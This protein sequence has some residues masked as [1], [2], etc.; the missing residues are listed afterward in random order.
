MFRNVLLTLCL[1]IGAT[2]SH[3]ANAQSTDDGPFASAQ[4][5]TA[6]WQGRRAP[7]NCGYVI[8]ENQPIWTNACGFGP[9]R[10]INYYYCSNGW[11]YRQCPPN[12]PFG[13]T[14]EITNYWSNWAANRNVSI[15]VYANGT[16]LFSKNTGFGPPISYHYV[17]CQNRRGY[18][19]NCS[20]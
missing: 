20:L 1:M 12:G 5:L 2:L 15:Y 13:Y 8:L 14:F 19:T 6:H 17:Y 9:Y 7:P 11:I 4:Q 16:L 3:H 10:N 18:M